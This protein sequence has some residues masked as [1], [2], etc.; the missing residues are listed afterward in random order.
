MELVQI[1]LPL[2]GQLGLIVVQ[3]AM[4]MHFIVLPLALIVAAV[5]VVEFALSIPHAILL[6]PLVPA[7]HLVLLDHIFGLVVA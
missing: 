3:F 1:P 4:A 6:I 5:L 7:S 2:V